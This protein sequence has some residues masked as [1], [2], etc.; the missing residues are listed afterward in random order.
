MKNLS[1]HPDYHAYDFNQYPGVVNQWG[2][3]TMFLTRLGYGGGWTIDARAGSEATIYN[4]VVNE[5]ENVHYGITG[6]QKL[7]DVINVYMASWCP[8]SVQPQ[9][10]AN[11][12]AAWDQLR[13]DYPNITFVFMTGHNDGTGEY[14]PLNPE[15]MSC[16]SYGPC[17][18]MNNKAIRQHVIE[19][20]GALFD[21]ADIEEYDPAGNY[22]LDKCVGESLNYKPSG[23]CAAWGGETS[24]WATEYLNNHT[25]TL[26]YELIRGGPD[27]EGYMTDCSHSP[28]DDSNYLNYPQHRDMELNCALKGQ[29]AWWLWARLA[30]WDG[31]PNHNC[32]S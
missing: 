15:P 24:N 2:Y 21:F 3:S 9:V 4:E 8:V 10:V 25:N 27:G 6:T 16:G 29:A 7:K 17:A 32:T 28:G 18:N 13:E 26:N 19:T 20:G 12:L 11:Y 30:G 1:S 31:N 5:L 14:D 23:D 22:F